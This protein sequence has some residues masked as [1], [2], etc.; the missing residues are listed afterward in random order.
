M[1]IALPAP[2]WFAVPPNGYGGIE[3]LGSGLADGLTQRGHHRPPFA[4]R[5][6]ATQAT[7]PP[8]YERAPSDR[9][10][11]GEPELN[12]ALAC[13]ERSDEFDV[14]HDLTG[15]SGAA[16]AGASRAPVVHTIQCAPAGEAYA[17]LRRAAAI[18]PS[19][20]LVSVSL[21]QQRLAPGLPWIANCPN[22]LDL[23]AYPFSPSRGDYLVFL[24][25]I[26]PTK[27]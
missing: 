20:S 11:A 19:L 12:H 2:V 16:L 6:S 13:L 10:R 3:L 4:P 25:R 15:L 26:H 21:N 5:E 23:A 7:L 27:S 8:P 1:K 9:P 22:G 14:V 24:G 17:I 18:R